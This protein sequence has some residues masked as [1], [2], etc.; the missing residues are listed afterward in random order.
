MYKSIPKTEH[1]TDAFQVEIV[2]E[3]KTAAEVIKFLIHLEK[4]N[5][6]SL[7]RVVLDCSSTMA[8]VRTKRALS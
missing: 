7:K 5:R 6:N 1:G 8:K 2:K 4:I 3:I